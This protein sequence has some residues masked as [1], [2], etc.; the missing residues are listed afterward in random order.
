MARIELAG[1]GK[2][3]HE[4]E[5]NA[6]TALS[7]IDLVIDNGRI[8]VLQGPSGSGK[9]TLLTLAGC[10]ARPTSGRVRLDG[11]VVSGLP[12]RFTAELRRKR[13]GF[14]FQQFNLIAGLSVRDNVMLPAYPTASGSARW[15]RGPMRCSPGSTSPVARTPGSNRFRVASSSGWPSPGR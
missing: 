3:Y 6:F 10:L 13:F 12:E 8:T 4:G 2:V 14:V 5:P 1:I 11:E 9:T 7:D 15:S